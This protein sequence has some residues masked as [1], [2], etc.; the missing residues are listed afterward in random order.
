[1]TSYDEVGP[2]YV[3]RHCPSSTQLRYGSVWFGD[4]VGW[5]GTVPGFWDGMVSRMCLVR[6][7]ESSSFFV[8]FEGWHRM[9]MDVRLTPLGTLLVDPTCHP[10]I[11]FLPPLPPPPEATTRVRRPERRRRRAQPWARAPPP[12]A[13]VGRRAVAAARDASAAPVPTPTPPPLPALAR[14][15]RPRRSSLH[16]RLA[17]PDARPLPAARSAS[18]CPVAHPAAQLIPSRRRARPRSSP[19]RKGAAPLEGDAPLPPPLPRVRPPPAST[20]G[21]SEDGVRKRG[22]HPSSSRFR[23]GMRLTRIMEEY[24]LPGMVP[25]LAPLIQTP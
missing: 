7:T 5:N 3:L 12:R 6:G 1:M 2:A 22:A 23:F 21:R 16:R 9:W 19:C 4:E 10:P 14:L 8:W 17:R 20:R 11:H 25:S 24:S 18:P 13:P 15:R